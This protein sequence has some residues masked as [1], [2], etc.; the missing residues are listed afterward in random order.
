MS[1]RPRVLFVF[2]RPRAEREAAYRAGDA[3]DDAFYGLH[4]LRER[5]FDTFYSDAGHE[6]TRLGRVYKFIDDTISR[7]GSRTGFHWWQ[8]KQLADVAN[9]ADL[10]FATAD[11]SALPFLWLRRRGIVRTPIVYATIGLVHTYPWALGRVARFYRGLMPQASRVVHF[12]HGE[13]ARLIGDFG[14]DPARVRH[15]PFGVDA[16]FYRSENSPTNPAAAPLAFGMDERR[17]WKLLA[18]AMNGCGMNLDLVTHPRFVEGIALPEEIRRIDPVSFRALRSRIAAAPFL[19][20]PVKENPYTGATI[21]LL[22]AMA[23][24][25]AAIVSRTSAIAQGYG[26]VDGDN[27]IFVAPGDPTAMRDA[28]ADLLA[29]SDKARRIGDAAAT[30][31]L[32]GYTI[33]HMADALAEIFRESLAE[34]GAR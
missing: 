24:G 28:A 11:S 29:D 27:V 34:G 2:N 32:S 31:V 14:V 25:K 20:F 12:G 30:H 22:S 4:A 18:Q 33:A 9:E 15:V 21:S 19:V 23:M 13:G 26:L 8:A 5:G 16:D 17:D 6:F 3:P 10:V 7:Q 1:D